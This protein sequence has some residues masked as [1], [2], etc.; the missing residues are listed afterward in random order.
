MSEIIIKVKDNKDVVH[1]L[2]RVKIEILWIPYVTQWATLDPYPPKPLR[3]I[4]IN[5]NLIVLKGQPFTHS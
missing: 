4:C 3:N 5:Q 2:R 1:I